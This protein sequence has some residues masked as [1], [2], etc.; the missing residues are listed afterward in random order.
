MANFGPLP[1]W[2]DHHSFEANTDVVARLAALFEAP[3][4]FAPKSTMER[5]HRDIFDRIRAIP[6][7][8]STTILSTYLDMLACH[9]DASRGAAT[10]LGDYL[11]FREIDVGMPIC[12]AL[13]YW[14]EDM[15]L[16]EAEAALLAPLERVAN[17][18]VSIL[19]DVFSFDREW[20]AAKTLGQGA[21]LVNGV[22]IL[23]DEVGVS[24]GAAKRLC[25]AL[26]RAWE[27]EFLDMAE[28]VM[29]GTEGG[30]RIRLARAV[31]GI[32]RRMSGAEGF[33]WRTSRYS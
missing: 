20:K 6:S 33:S 18:H 10:T 30:S 27:V 17:Y 5:M 25:F 2:F 13:L 12:R 29:E 26:V 9:C 32:E 24:V 22:R 3:S 19:N 31:K 14:T 23:A 21:V 16:S 7:K 4:T 11:V 1:D 8:A 28:A 15:V